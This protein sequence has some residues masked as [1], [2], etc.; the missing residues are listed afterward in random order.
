[1]ASGGGSQSSSS[2]KTEPWIAQQPFLKEIYGL[3]QNLFQGDPYQYGPDREAGLTEPM[4][5]ALG[6]I[7][8]LSS[9]GAPGVRQA[10]DLNARVMGGEFLSPESN[11]YLRANFD[12]AARGVTRQFQESVMPTLNTRFAQGR[13]QQDVG[14]NAMTAAQGRAQDELGRNLSGLASRMYGDNYAAERTRMQEAQ[15][16]APSL[17]SAQYSGA[18]AGLGAG[19]VR[20]DFAQRALDDIVQRFSFNQYAPAERLAEYS[21]FIGQP[22]STSQ[23]R[24]SSSSFQFGIL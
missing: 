3:A 1:M 24:S 7:E 8:N 23:G 20:Q 17:L 11:P 5:S 21:G 4:Q 13:T 19:Q 6:R 2:N 14:Q 15:R 10:Q 16:M 18:Q 9:L 12:E 22:V